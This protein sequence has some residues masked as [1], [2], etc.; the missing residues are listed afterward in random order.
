MATDTPACGSAA[1]LGPGAD[2]L[3]RSWPDPAVTNPSSRIA[4]LRHAWE[5]AI[6]S[7]RLPCHPGPFDRVPGP[8]SSPRWG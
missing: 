4:T 2:V 6:W 8:V 7:V 3:A 1:V 5:L